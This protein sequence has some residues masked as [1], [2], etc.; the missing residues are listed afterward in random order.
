MAACPPPPPPPPPCNGCPG[1]CLACYTCVCS[2]CQCAAVITGIYL[3][4][5][6]SDVQCVGDGWDFLLSGPALNYCSCVSWSTNPPGDPQGGTGCTFS[7]HWDTPGEK[8]VTA[9]TPC[10]SKSRTVTVQELCGTLG[11]CCGKN[12][13][14]CGNEVCCDADKVCCWALDGSYYCNPPCWDE[15]TNTTSCSKD[16]EATYNECHGCRQLI[17]LTCGMYRV[18]TGL[19]IK[20]CYDGCPQFDW[21]TEEKDCYTIKRCH[22]Q[23]H[24]QSWCHEC[25]GEMICD[26]ILQVD[27]ECGSI[28]ACLIIIAC[29][30]VETCYQCEK[31]DEVVSTHTLETCSCR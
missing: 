31:G 26:P 12:K 17:P 19:Q 11:S 3:E 18:Y 27:D 20:T 13:Y 25:N 24:E 16:K 10:S 22:A 30:L 2:S 8:T 28:G 9:T 29:D 23:Q 4:Y 21:N 6:E 7:T 14:C 15:V 5:N 1:G